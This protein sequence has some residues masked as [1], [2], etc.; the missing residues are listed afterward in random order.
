MS[1]LR[2][3]PTGPPILSPKVPLIILAP[4]KLSQGAS[5]IPRLLLMRF[6]LALMIS[7]RR[8]KQ[9]NNRL[10][11]KCNSNNKRKSKHRW[12]KIKQRL[13]N[14]PSLQSSSDQA[15][16]QLH[17]L[18]PTRR[19]HQLLL[20]LPRLRRFK[21]LKGTCHHLQPRRISLSLCLSKLWWTRP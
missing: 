10:A 17:S 1:S 12:S 4:S 11:A 20:Q 5:R 2:E 6:S 3:T 13:E 21:P 19:L 15:I 18:L 7:I 9:I 14:L 8:S 16:N